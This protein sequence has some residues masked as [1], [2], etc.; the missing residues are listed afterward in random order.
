MR[1]MA[2]RAE[3][4][5]C[6]AICWLVTLRAQM[7]LKSLRRGCRQWNEI[8]RTEVSMV[9]VATDKEREKHAGVWG[10]EWCEIFSLT[11]PTRSRP[12]SGGASS[13]SLV[14]E[15]STCQHD[16]TIPRRESRRALSLSLSHCFFLPSSLPSVLICKLLSFQSAVLNSRSSFDTCARGEMK[17]SV[18][19]Y[20]L[21]VDRQIDGDWFEI[22]NVWSS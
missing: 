8:R 13:T 1:E 16:F 19:C 7:G 22:L 14:G 11:T 4:T 21:D 12:A 2:T 9:Y 5:G 17:C 18:A 15:G 20:G 10:W 6:I 3:K